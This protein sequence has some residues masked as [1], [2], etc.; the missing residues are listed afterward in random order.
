MWQQLLLAVALVLVI[1]AI[2]P[3]LSPRAYRRAI[4]ALMQLDDRLLRAWALSSMLL[5]A[6]LVYLI[7][8]P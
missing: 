7:T 5:G 2:I 6:L 1:E 4:A 3:S 8:H